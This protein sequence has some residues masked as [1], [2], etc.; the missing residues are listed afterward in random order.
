MTEQQ[1][2]LIT[3]EAEDIL[4]NEQIVNTLVSLKG[5]WADECEYED[6]SEYVDVVKN[7]VESQ[8]YKF[9]K[10]TKTFALTLIGKHFTYMIKFNGVYL[11]V[12]LVK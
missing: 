1:K 7:V 4:H 6:F 11:T 8:G 12:T 3:K 2:E 9:V 5:R 10:L